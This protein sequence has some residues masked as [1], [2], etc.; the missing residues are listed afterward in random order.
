MSEKIKGAR[1]SFNKLLND[2][3][4]GKTGFNK[5]FKYFCK[6]LIIDVIS[7]NKTKSRFLPETEFLNG[8]IYLICGVANLKKI[9]PIQLR[10]MSYDIFRQ[11][12]GSDWNI[13]GR[14]VNIETEGFDEYNIRKGTVCFLPPYEGNTYENEDANIPVSYGG[15]LGYSSR[16]EDRSFQ[17]QEPSNGSGEIWSSLI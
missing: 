11:N 3:H 17:V 14:I 8:G 1:S 6:A 12:Y 2:L 13:I 4:V 5:D 10:G 16:F 7:G 15:V 9:V